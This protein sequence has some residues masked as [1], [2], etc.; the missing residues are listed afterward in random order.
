MK[1]YAL[2]IAFLAFT[3]VVAG[4]LYANTVTNTAVFTQSGIAIDNTPGL[5]PAQYAKNIY[6]LYLNTV[7]F[8]GDTALTATLTGASSAA[9]VFIGGKTGSTASYVKSIVMS[10]NG[11]T[12]L[13]TMSAPTTGT[14][15][16]LAIDYGPRTY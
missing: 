8:A 1:R 3:G 5:P 11:N 2:L 4:M 6:G 16:L 15:P 7:A 10:V 13:V 14:L 12:A 9:K